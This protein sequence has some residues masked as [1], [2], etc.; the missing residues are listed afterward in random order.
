M[1]NILIAPW[2]LTAV[3]AGLVG[4]MPE[5]SNQLRQKANQ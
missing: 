5:Q 2:A 1:R 3:V 4:A